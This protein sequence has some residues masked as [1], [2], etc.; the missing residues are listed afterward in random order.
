MSGFSYDSQTV[1]VSLTAV[2]RVRLTGY[3]DDAALCEKIGTGLKVRINESEYQVVDDLNARVSQIASSTAA[4]GTK[5]MFSF[6]MRLDQKMVMSKLKVAS[7]P[8]DTQDAE[9]RFELSH[10]A[11]GK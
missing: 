9:F 4:A 5:D 2:L 3:E 11:I 1:D 10:F 7:Y 6:T 8:F